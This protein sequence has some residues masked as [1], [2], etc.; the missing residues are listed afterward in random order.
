MQSVKSENQQE[1]NCILELLSFEFYTILN[2]SFALSGVEY[3]C[4]WRT[5]TVQCD[6]MVQ[7]STALSALKLQCI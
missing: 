1:D 4:F 7:E 6:D 5:R 2:K 3:D